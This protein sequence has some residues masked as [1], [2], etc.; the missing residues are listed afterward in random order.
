MNF[1][2]MDEG[3]VAAMSYYQRNTYEA[4]LNLTYG[5][6]T[7]TTSYFKSRVFQDMDDYIFYMYL[8]FELIQNSLAQ[9]V[10]QAANKVIFSITYLMVIEI[11]L[12]GLLLSFWLVRL[13]GEKKNLSNLYGA[14][15]Q[16][17]HTLFK[18]NKII[19]HIL[20]DNLCLK[21]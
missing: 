17:P 19:M 18:E 2:V 6:I 8:M 21:Y 5:N 14:V 7:D 3:M 9:G 16:L 20:K 11:A 10:G 12:M 13:S 1:G 4:L 15:L